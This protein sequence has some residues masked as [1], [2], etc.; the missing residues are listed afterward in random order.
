MAPR[1]AAAAVRVSI[2]C[3]DTPLICWAFRIRYYHYHHHRQQQQQQ[4]NPTMTS[5]KMLSPCVTSSTLKS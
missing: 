2:T 4:R 1:K 3:V 5:S